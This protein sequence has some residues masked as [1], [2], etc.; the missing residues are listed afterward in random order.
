MDAMGYMECEPNEKKIPVGSIYY[1]QY[2]ANSKYFDDSLMVEDVITTQRAAI[3][4]NDATIVKALKGALASGELTDDQE[5]VAGRIMQ[6]IENGDI[7]KNIT[8]EIVKEMKTASNIVA[9]F[10]IIRD[11]IDDTYL[12]ER[13]RVVLPEGDKEV[14]LSCYMKEQE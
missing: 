7:P 4:G 2:Q 6:A 1:D 5:A 9:A 8:K 14:I 10:A 13:K 3:R 12:Y 11:N